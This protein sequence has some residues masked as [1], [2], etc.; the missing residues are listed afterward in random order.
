LV[1]KLIGMADAAEVSKTDGIGGLDADRKR[2]IL[3]QQK[4]SQSFA[5]PAIGIAA[6]RALLGQRTPC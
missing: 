2:F 5:A 6:A 3:G 1:T 4:T